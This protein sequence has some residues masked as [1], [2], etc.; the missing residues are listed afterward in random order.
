MTPTPENHAEKLERAIHQT[1]R[2]LPPRRAP[3]TLEARVFAELER[4]AALPWWRRNFAHWPTAVQCAFFVASAALAAL[5][6][7]GLF[8]MTRNVSSAQFASEVAGRLSG[9]AFARELGATIVTS[10]EAVWRSIPSLWLYG[11]L[12]AIAACYATLIGVGAAAYRT[13]HVQR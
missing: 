9:L 2:A 3:R 7:V 13:F 6:A 4:L 5:L 1:L 8:A 12:A 11:A 10:A